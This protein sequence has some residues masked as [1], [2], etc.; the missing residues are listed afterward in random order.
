MTGVQTCALPIS[1]L[2]IS[3]VLGEIALDIPE[4]TQPI[5]VVGELMPPALLTFDA[6]SIC[7]ESD[8]APGEFPRREENTFPLRELP[9]MGAGASLLDFLLHA[10][11]L[12][13]EHSS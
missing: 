10:P 11:L 8:E 1:L 12:P 13:R 4:E 2:Q 5:N 6:E 7:V 3:G 9:L